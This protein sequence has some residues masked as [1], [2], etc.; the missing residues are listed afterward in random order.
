MLVSEHP[1]LRGDR[2]SRDV[3]TTEHPKVLRALAADPAPEMSE[4]IDDL[5]RLVALSSVDEARLREAIMALVPDFQ[6][7]AR[8]ADVI[9]ITLRTSAEHRTA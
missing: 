8:G 4:R 5:L 1:Q 9:P 3:R 6:I 7:P 2:R